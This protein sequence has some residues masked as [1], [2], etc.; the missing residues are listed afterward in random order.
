MRSRNASQ[1]SELF[2]T[3]CRYS[4][5]RARDARGR[6]RCARTPAARRARRCDRSPRAPGEDIEAARAADTVKRCAP[7]RPGSRAAPQWKPRRWPPSRACRRI[8][9]RLREVYG[10][11]LMRPHGHPIAELVLTVLSQ[12]TND[13]NRDVAYLRLRERLPTWEAVMHAPVAEVEEAISPG[14]ISKVKSVRIQAILRGDRRRPARPRVRAVARLARARADRA[15]ARL[16]DG[17]PR[18]GA[19]DGGVRAAVR[20]RPA[21]GAGRHARL[22]RGHAPRAAARGRAV[23]RA[24]RPDARAH[25]AGRGARAARQPAAPRTAHLPRALARLRGVRACAHVPE[26]QAVRRRAPLSRAA[27]PRTRSPRSAAPAATI[28]SAW[29]TS[30]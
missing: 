30:W 7:T 16:P 12:S 27:A 24:P 14:G 28:T 26:P 19:Q 10:V 21:R 3:P 25:A 6:G 18:R 29:K 23:R 4:G 13:R 2:G 5:R 8:R 22:A 15:G 1:S 17:A 20:L 9:D 11:P